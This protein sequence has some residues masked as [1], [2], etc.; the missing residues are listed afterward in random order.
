MYSIINDNINADKKE[1]FA[2]T[3]ELLKTAE[4]DKRQY[5]K[6]AKKQLCKQLIYQ[7]FSNVKPNYEDMIYNFKEKY[8][9]NEAKVEYNDDDKKLELIGLGYMYDY[10]QDYKPAESDFNIF[11]EGMKLHKLLYKAFD[12]SRKEEKEKKYEEL[13]QQLAEAKKNKD[14]KA[15]KSVNEELKSFSEISQ[16]FGGSLR[17]E[18][19][20]LLNVDYHVPSSLEA[21]LFF[22][23][24]LNKERIIEYNNILSTPDIF[25]YIE[26]CVK[27]CVQIIKYQPFTNGNKRTARALLNL[28][29]KNRNIP[30]VYI[31]CKERKAYKEALLKAITDED[32]QDIIDFY[33]F[34]IC[35]S[36]Y[37][38]DIVPYLN[39]KNNEKE[40]KNYKI[41]ELEK[42][43][44]EK[45]IDNEEKKPDER[46]DTIVYEIKRRNR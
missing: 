10:I 34:K 30:P 25:G 19:V 42:L 33:Y 41:A 28:L 45:E 3:F 36:I 24:F 37:E 20:D 22:N 23:S 38:L 40:K 31:K 7:Y 15:F 13:Q 32:Y 12:D 2:L 44:K 14:L 18:E 17:K 21:Q 39:N 1:I 43:L 8:I 35:D 6:L 4:T 16:A 46:D 9:D 29:F 11:I 26:Y 27:T 5:T